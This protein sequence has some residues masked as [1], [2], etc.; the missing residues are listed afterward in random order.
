MQLHT[1]EKLSFFRGVCVHV[2]VHVAGSEEREVKL[3]SSLAELSSL[4]VFR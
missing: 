2:C 4:E 3:H 1:P